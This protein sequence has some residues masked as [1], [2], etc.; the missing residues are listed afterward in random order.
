M[1]SRRTAEWKIR[2][3]SKWQNFKFD[4]REWKNRVWKKYNNWKENLWFSLH[5]RILY[6]DKINQKISSETSS[7]CHGLSGIDSHYHGSEIYID[8]NKQLFVKIKQT[9]IKI[10]KF[11][12]ISLY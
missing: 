7:A 9:T 2:G 11:V 1:V 4:V 12:V 10:S 6:D 5:L 8:G 3:K